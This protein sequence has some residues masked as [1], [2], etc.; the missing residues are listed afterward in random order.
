MLQDELVIKE[1]SFNDLD[2]CLFTTGE[3]EIITNG[4]ISELE[5]Q[6]RLE[7]LKQFTYFN[8]SYPWS[9]LKNVYIA[10][11]RKIELG[12]KTWNSNFA[13]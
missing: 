2:F 13:M 7:L 12:H 1:L 3:L 9:V 5:K 11:L 6:S 8:G 10:I 4:Y